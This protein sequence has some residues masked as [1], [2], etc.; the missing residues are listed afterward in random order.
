[1]SVLAKALIDET[2]ALEGATA[3]VFFVRTGLRS[4]GEE[5]D[6]VEDFGRK[7][8]EHSRRRAVE[9]VCEVM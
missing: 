3:F 6:L 2:A 8:V 1:L 9:V 7:T 5:E 4:A